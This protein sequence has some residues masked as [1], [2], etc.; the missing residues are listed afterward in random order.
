MIVAGVARADLVRELLDGNE[1]GLSGRA[2]SPALGGISQQTLRSDPLKLSCRH[3]W[4]KSI[5]RH[6]SPAFVRDKSYGAS[7]CHFFADYTAS[8]IASNAQQSLQWRL[9]MVV[10]YLRLLELLAM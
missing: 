3:V 5:R 6:N 4:M 1:S 8:S 10:S 9:S 2:E 7:S